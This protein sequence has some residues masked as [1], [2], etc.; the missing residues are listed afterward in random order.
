VQA[1]TPPVDPPLV[2]I[3]ILRVEWSCILGSFA[4]DSYVTA[5]YGRSAKAHESNLRACGRS[6]IEEGVSLKASQETCQ[7]GRLTCCMRR[8]SRIRHMRLGGLIA[9]T[10]K[11]RPASS[12]TASTETSIDG[13][14]LVIV[15]LTQ[16]QH[17]SSLLSCST[18]AFT[19]RLRLRTAG[20][21]DTRLGRDTQ[22]REPL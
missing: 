18:T 3:A 20:V 1:H 12:T 10:G 6:N 5:L 19:I 21:P 14:A 9:R 15:F 13:G 22:T 16:S 4:L 8:T 7:P 17:F 11:K 2:H